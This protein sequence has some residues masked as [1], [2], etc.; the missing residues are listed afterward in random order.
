MKVRNDK[1]RNEVLQKAI[2]VEEKTYQ[3]IKKELGKS[4]DYFS[5]EELKKLA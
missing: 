1:K 2:Y 4:D 3:Q 5:L